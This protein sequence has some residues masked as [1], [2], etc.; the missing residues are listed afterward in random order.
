MCAC[1]ISYPPALLLHLPSSLYVDI[2]KL[3]LCACL[4]FSLSLFLF[5]YYYCFLRQSLVLFPRLKYSGMISAHHNLRLLGSIDPPAP[6][7]QVAGT[8][9]TCH[10]AQLTFVFLVEM[11]FC[12]VVQTCLELQPGTT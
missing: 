8:T 7:S 6:A 3:R 9:G 1:L 12:H 2:S 10:H 11:R 5:I 4:L